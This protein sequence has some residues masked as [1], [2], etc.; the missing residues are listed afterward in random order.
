[1][2]V[3]PSGSEGGKPGRTGEFRLHPGTPREQSFGG[4]GFYTLEAGDTFA[5]AAAGGG[6]Y[7][8]PFE[9]ALEAVLADVRAGWVSVEDAARDYGVA[10]V[11]GLDG[12]AIDDEATTRLRSR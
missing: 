12:H 3:P 10:I 2:K 9:R 8:D 6:G 4:S 7:G 11:H 1:M 5:V